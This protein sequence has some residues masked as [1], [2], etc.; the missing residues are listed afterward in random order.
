MTTLR[1]TVRVVLDVLIGRLAQ[2]LVLAFHR[3]VDVVNPERLRI[4]GPTLLVANHANGFVDPAVVAA[5][6]RRVPRFVA[7]S[8]LWDFVVARPFLALAGV[9]PVY[10][11]TDG[12]TA[13]NV[14]TFRAIHD[15]L[16]AGGA[17]A[18]FPEGTSSDRP[19]LE[20]LRTGAARMALGVVD[21]APEITILPIGLS[22]ESK[23]EIRPAVAVFVGEP[24]HVHAWRRAEHP[25]AGEDDHDAV[26][27][28]TTRIQDRL[29][30]VSPEF[31]SLDERLIL[32]A[33]ATVAARETDRRMRPRFGDVEQI[34][35]TLAERPDAVRAT[36][37]DRYR[38]YAT[39]LSLIGLHEDDL[40]TRAEF[41]QLA[42]PGLSVAAVALAGPLMV[43][44][45][46]IH[47]P[48]LMAVRIST[49]AVR[50]HV[51]KGTTR[52]LV[53]LVAGPTTWI[54]A[55]VVLADGWAAA[56]TAVGVAVGGV[57][58]LALWLP[59][60]T[61]ARR[62]FGRLRMYDRRRLAEDSIADRDDVV[63]AVQSAL[64]S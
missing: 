8:T 5:S 56:L 22:F 53:G 33:A 32:R 1:R 54:I 10:R 47:L 48:A 21:R 2:L 62:V 17:V 3:R 38:D 14:S 16:A 46:L 19:A 61:L 60:F 35:R 6:L 63:R 23:V 30:A 28:L 13:G 43:T 39:R 15:V 55:G 44:I 37:V 58:A 41:R 20:Q 18:V 4:D 64:A 42:R 45:T 26:R 50:S 49:G 12:A 24:I 52:L 57:I 7:K 40:E 9:I 51:K 31:A 29:G 11:R 34:A 59:L 27:A 36:V 25:G